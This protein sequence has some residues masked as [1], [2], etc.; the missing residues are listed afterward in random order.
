M[1]MNNYLHILSLNPRHI[2]RSIVITQTYI[3]PT[4]MDTTRLRN[5][6]W[7][8]PAMRTYER[9]VT[10]ALAKFYFKLDSNKRMHMLRSVARE[11]YYESGGRIYK[12]M[13]NNS[14]VLVKQNMEQFIKIVKKRLDNI[15]YDDILSGTSK[16]DYDHYFCNLKEGDRVLVQSRSSLLYDGVFQFNS[17]INRHYCYIDFDTRSHAIRWERRL[18]QSMD[19]DD[20]NHRRITRQMTRLQRSIERESLQRSGQQNHNV[21]DIIEDI[22]TD[23][24]SFE[25]L[26][27]LFGDGTENM[28]HFDENWLTQKGLIRNNVQGCKCAICLAYVE[29]DIEIYNIKCG[30]NLLHPLH[31]QC[32]KD[33]I[34]SKATSCPSCRYPWE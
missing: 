32:A 18:V 15:R 1:T 20:T 21:E 29:K 9:V 24:T 5:H 16:E 33:L 34:R 10:P 12:R 25:T 14:D 17:V 6:S 3:R 31:K 28:S 13:N 26:S 23:G 4:F 8:T 11:L 27:A 22:V 7:P 2:S 19:L 30:E